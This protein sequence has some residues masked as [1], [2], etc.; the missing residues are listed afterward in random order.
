MTLP[1]P[2]L[3]HVVVNT[4]DRLDDVA[5]LWER[6]GFTLTP[7]GH[8]TLGSQNNLAIL[9]ADYIELLGVPPGPANRTDVLDWPA[10]LNGLVFKDWD[11]DR[12]HAALH[13]AG[14]PVLPPQSF[15][16]PVDM[17]SGPRDAAFRT[18]RLHRDAAP[19]GRL[20][21]CHHQTPELVWHDGWRRHPNG[22]VAVAGATVAA[23]DPSELLGLFAQMF[24]ADAVRD[25]VLVAGLARVEVL[26]HD[27]LRARLGDAAP[28]GDGRLQFMAALELRT[29]SLGRVDAALE[30]GRVPHA[31][32]TDAVTVAAGQAGGVTLVFRE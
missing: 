18:V 31:R 6:L 4:L 25:G 3:D 11:A 17:P 30:A 20:F 10:G 2:V 16:R 12:T 22:V 24:G 14:V 29:L 13:G 8:H 1:V 19:A 9:G 5:A 32:G 7:R 15:S 27:A 23:A 28:D 26:T 21:F